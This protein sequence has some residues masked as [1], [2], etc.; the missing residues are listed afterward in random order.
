MC[1]VGFKS[2][3]KEF[4]LFSVRSDGDI[5]DD[6]AI[7]VAIE[8]VIQVA[9]GTSVKVSHDSEF[10]ASAHTLRITSVIDRRV[11]EY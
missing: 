9:A 1:L 4:S 8:M 2:R 5:E 10:A 7:A 3:E 6:D 11:T